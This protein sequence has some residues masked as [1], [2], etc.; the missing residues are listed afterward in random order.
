MA[1]SPEVQ[2]AGI[3]D[4]QMSEWPEVHMARSPDGQMTGWLEVQIT[5]WPDGQKS[6]W[7]DVQK[8]RRPNTIYT[9]IYRYILNE[10]IKQILKYWC[11]LGDLSYPSNNPSV[12]D[13]FGGP[14][15]VGYLGRKASRQ[16]IFCCFCSDDDV[17]KRQLD[18]VTCQNHY[19]FLH[20]HPDIYLDRK[21]IEYYT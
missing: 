18:L 8:T 11:S 7:P 9:Y 17:W 16:G 21:W 12:D 1:W 19:A 6:K 20:Y 3:P 5:R 15:V 14:V 13:V 2:M 10:F 4:G